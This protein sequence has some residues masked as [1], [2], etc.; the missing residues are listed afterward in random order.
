MRY[1]KYFEN[2]EKDYK[3]YEVGDYVL[4]DLESMKREAEQLRKKME[5]R[6]AF[7]WSDTDEEDEEFYKEDYRYGRIYMAID[8][9][10]NPYRV[11]FSDGVI[12]DVTRENIIRFLNDEEIEEYESKV[13]AIKYNL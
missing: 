1:L 13:D 3:D 6:G 4:L 11:R 2:H 8:R 12:Y 9:D 5:L 7:D 10:Y